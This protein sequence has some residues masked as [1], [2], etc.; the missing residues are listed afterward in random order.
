MIKAAGIVPVAFFL[1]G[2]HA[3]W[4]KMMVLESEER[5]AE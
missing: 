3:R 1:S 2:G 4:K 5:R